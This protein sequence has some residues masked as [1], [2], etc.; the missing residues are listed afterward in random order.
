MDKK[1]TTEKYTFHY[2][3]S[4]LGVVLIDIMQ[5][6]SDYL[7]IDYVLLLE[8]GICR[9]YLT[10]KGVKEAYEIGEKLL[11]NNFFINLTKR[12]T[13]VKNKIE[14]YRGAETFDVNGWIDH[15]SLWTELLNI[16]IFCDESTWQPI[17]NILREK[18]SDREITD[19]LNS[20]SDFD[21]SEREKYA[22]NVLKT[23][24][25]V[26]LDLHLGAD[27]LIK[28]GLNKFCELFKNKFGISDEQFYLMRADE[29]EHTLGGGEIPFEKIKERR[30]GTVFFNNNGI[31]ECESGQIFHDWK[32]EIDKSEPKEIKGTVAYRGK[33][34]GRVV[35]HLMWSGI[36]EVPDGSILVT[37]MTNPQMVPYIKNVAA[38]VVD[39]GGLTCHAAIISR[40][41]KK[42]CI[43]GAKV[44]TKILKDGDMVEVDA[45]NGVVKI[46]SKN[47]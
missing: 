1:K 12:F 28:T 17:E 5:G 31:W 19:I 33:V 40:E 7:N 43:V 26:K 10:E 24:G 46:L 47:G 29:I 15:L 13:E 30:G 45:D 18:Y 20:E 11:D 21:L 27:K 23:M 32:K 36:T 44:A 42:P 22:V 3:Q 6:K 9:G 2:S 37:G 8:D 39:E 25:H 16:Y 35:K 41:M 34:I 38:I 14:N 4:D